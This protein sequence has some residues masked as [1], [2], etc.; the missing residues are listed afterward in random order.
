MSSIIRPR[1]LAHEACMQVENAVYRQ[2]NKSSPGQWRSISYHMRR[3]SHQLDKKKPT[4]MVRIT[5]GARSF[6]ALLES[7]IIA[8]VESAC[9]LDIKLHVE[10]LSG[11][12]LPLTSNELRSSVP[13]VIR[14]LPDTPSNGS[15]IGARGIAEAGS[16]GAWVDFQ[17]VGNAEKQRCF[18]TCHHVI[19]PGDP[20]NKS[21]ND[22]R[23]IGLEGR[24]IKT[25]IRVDYPA[26]S[27]DTET[28]Q[29]LQ[30]E[31]AQGND[32]DG[33][34]AQLINDINK[35]VSAG[36][37]GFAIHASGYFRQNRHGRRMDWALVRAHRSSTSQCNKPPCA[38]FSPVQLLMG[39]LLYEVKA[40]EVISKHACTTD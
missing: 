29:F 11:C 39:R 12:V 20:A 8:A 38:F 3:P 40:D 22:H 33:K 16:V 23:G 13:I 14:E 31:I 19:S 34:K 27:N 2:V 21:L 6:W 18:L 28:K 1:T 10:I 36:G 37:I 32:S 30:Q 5:P 7:H 35:Y 25:P 9:T 24:Q 4:V 17:P 26:P 15:S